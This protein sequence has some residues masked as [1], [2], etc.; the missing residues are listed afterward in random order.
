MTHT[1]RILELLYDRKDGAFL[2]DELAGA[3]GLDAAGVAAA[4]DEL[5]RRGHKL[6]LSPSH[7]VR[8]VGPVRPDARLIEHG[9]GTRRIGRSVICFDTVDSTSDVAFDSARQGG[10]DGLVVLAESQRHGRGRLGRQWISPPGANLLFSVLLTDAAPPGEALTIAAGLAVAEGI[11][12]ACGLACRVRWPNDVLLDGG[13]VAG[14]LVEVRRRARRRCVVL[15]I[16]INANAHPPPEHVG[17]PATSL[18]AHL[19]GAAD[20]IEV[21]RAVLRQLDLRV[22]QAAAG[23]L[24]ELH[25]GWLARCDMINERIT[26]WSRGRR[27]VGRVSDVDPLAGLILFDDDGRRIHLPAEHSTV[28]EG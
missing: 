2:L 7:G 13:K 17:R 22:R 20:R 6:E 5:R 19:S 24:D 9:L 23:E 8:L 16:G 3:A 25:S 11:E 14:V 10:T 18:A 12:S 26:V 21:V 27:Y 15:G 4:L 28:I 1:E